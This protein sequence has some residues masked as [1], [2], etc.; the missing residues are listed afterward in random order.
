MNTLSWSKQRDYLVSL[1]NAEKFEFF[2]EIDYFKEF[3]LQKFNNLVNN[4]Y[5]IIAFS[6]FSKLP[7][8]DIDIVLIPKNTFIPTKTNLKLLNNFFK[9]SREYN[10]KFIKKMFD[11]QMWNITID[12]FKEHYNFNK[13]IIFGNKIFKKYSPERMQVNNVSIKQ[14][15]EHLF[16]RTSEVFA[17][18]HFDRQQEKVKYAPPVFLFD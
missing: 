15:D 4:Y 1:V 17:Q 11:I 16:I 14:L 2:K 6:F 10:N 13:P 8:S 3:I 18:K 5:I 9:H 7:F 12:A